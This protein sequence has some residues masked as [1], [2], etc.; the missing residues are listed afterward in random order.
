VS[1]DRMR[2]CEALAVAKATPPTVTLSMFVVGN[3]RC[4]VALGGTD[5]VTVNA[6]VPV[7]SA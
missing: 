5:T 1:A 2:M 7:D 4:T 6:A 3:T